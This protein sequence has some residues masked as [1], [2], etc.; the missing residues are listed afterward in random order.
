MR[1]LLVQLIAMVT[2]AA[3]VALVPLFVGDALPRERLYLTAAVT[4]V[5]V[6]GWLAMLGTGR[7]SRG[8]P[9]RRAT[10]RAI[11]WGGNVVVA[12]MFWLCMPYASEAV[13][14][15]AVTGVFAT[16]AMQVLSAIEPPPASRR[17]ALLPLA[18]PVSLA[19]YFLVH[20]ERFSWV[21]APYS[22][23]YAFNVMTLRSIVQRAVD[24]AHAARET[25]EAA[26]VEVAAERDAKTRFLTSASHDLG[27]PLQAARLFFDQAM[28]GRTSAQR[29]A[30]ARK[31][32]WAFDA[33]EQL[34]RQML[35]HLRLESGAVAPRLE[36]VAVGPLIAR[37]AEMSEPAARLA[38]VTVLALPSRLHAMADAALTE[39]A[40]GNLVANGIRHAKAR[41][42]L[43]GARR[44]EG[45]VRLW[46]V[47]DGVGISEADAPRLFDDY[48][49][50]SD[51]GDEIRGGFGLGLSSA[52]RMAG[53]MA[54]AVG[55]DRKW[56]RG[57]AFWL[58]LPAAEA[59]AR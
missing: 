33:T 54:G 22:L 12:A 21:V 3:S 58:E 51:H 39:R 56:T 42:L 29:A 9:H 36:E 37:M 7:L 35:D 16:T 15:L 6:A 19:L 49:Q 27:Q 41:R 18:L 57:S 46:V 48:V 52:R 31:V 8:S 25:A 59:V 50:G 11:A 1:G 26:L 34:L 45:R 44:R 38:G 13:R 5:F 53:L 20:W 10:N 40:L 28:K 55:L 43:I 30:A 24:R 4:G 23:A 14:M 2:L 17:P 47:D 32:A